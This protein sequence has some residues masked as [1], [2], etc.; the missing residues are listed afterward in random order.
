M[1]TLVDLL[2]FSPFSDIS[3]LLQRPCPRNLSS[4][5]DEN[6]AVRSQ[7][8][9]DHRVNFYAPTCCLSAT[10][11]PP[12]FAFVRCFLRQK[13]IINFPTFCDICYVVFVLIARWRHRRLLKTAH[14]YAQL[15]TTPHNGRFYS[16]IN[17]ISFHGSRR[18]IFTGSCSATCD[19]MMYC[20]G[21]VDV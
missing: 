5:F 13:I 14:N 9:S 3:I 15:R 7:F 2:L 17:K 12:L 20:T 6:L 21:Y 11:V 19:V 1:V 10:F 8:D 18:F 16:F 4:K